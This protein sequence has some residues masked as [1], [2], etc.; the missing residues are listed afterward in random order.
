MTIRPRNSTRDFFVAGGTLK[1][2]APSYVEREADK[3]LQAL[4]Q[5]GQFAY[6]LTARQMGKSSLINRT[7]YQLK[8]SGVQTAIIDLT[9]IG[10]KTSDEE[11]YL[12][13]LYN[14]SRQLRLSVNVNRWWQER[15]WLGRVQRFSIF[16]QDV[17]LT[18][19][20]KQ[21]VI[22]V[23]EI[24]V[25]LSLDFSDDFFAV[26]RAVY[27]AR[28]QDPAF[29]RLIFVLSGVAS[30][31]DLIKERTL[32]PFNVGQA[33]LLQDF[34][35]NEAKK[36]QAGLEK[37]YP[38][39][40]EAI[41][42]RIYDWTDGHPYLTQMLCQEVV[43]GKGQKWADAQI[44]QLVEKIFISDNTRLKEQN[45][46]Q[47]QSR[48]LNHP[49]K[50]D[51]LALYQS[52]YQGKKVANDPQSLL[53]TQLKLSGVVKVNSEGDLQ[54]RNRIYAQAFDLSWVKNNI[55]FEF[56][57][58]GTWHPNHPSYVKPSADKE[59]LELVRSG[60]LAYQHGKRAKVGGL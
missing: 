51:L 3:E 16:L 35:R 27:N 13:L 48:I 25:T 60:Q 21:V 5:A 37:K 30:P 57:R 10:T 59:L 40:A 28:A 1:P 19:I 41:L 55:A 26:I 11:W 4:V 56:V 20:E 47:A 2:T 22:F 15:S 8:K 24:D 29:D 43:K 50:R 38:T 54:L 32:T 31:T 6:V 18:Q 58:G 45:L 23:D 39:E 7:A 44:D 14:L 49:Q 33:I 42:T 17:V 36:L 9:Q 12:G 34:S 52:I 46:Q 53:Q